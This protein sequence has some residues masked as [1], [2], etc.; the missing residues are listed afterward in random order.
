MIEA[1]DQNQTSAS[2]SL[3]VPVCIPVLEAELETETQTQ[4][5][6]TEAETQTAAT[7]PPQPTHNLNPKHYEQCTVTRG[8]PPEWIAVNV[9]SMNKKEAT[10]RLG[11]PAKSDGMF[12]EGYN[13][14]GQYKPDKPWKAEND[15]DK[16]AAKYRTAINEEYDAMLPKHPTN[17]QYWTDYIALQELAWKI[18]GHPYLLITEGLFK[19]IMACFCALPC[20]ALAGVEQGLTPSDKDPQGKR[21][22]VETLELLARQGFGFIIIFDADSATNINVG[23]A[24]YKL[25]KQLEK[26]KV[27]VYIS[28]GWDIS[29]GKGMDDYIQKNGIDQFKRE[30][31]GKIV[32]LS[33]WEKQ[34]V[35]KLNAQKQLPPS[36]SAL[37]LA[38]KY[39]HLWKHDLEQQTW[40]RYNDKVWE[41][42]ADKVFE[43]EVYTD[44]KLMPQV[45]FKHH[46]Y[47]KNVLE[48]LHLELM[49]RKWISFERSQWIAFND[50]VLE[51]AT[52]KKHNHAPGFMFTSNL[53]HNCPTLDWEKGGDILALCRLHAPSFFAYAM[54][55]QNGDALKVLKLLAFLNGTL[56]YRF[57]QLQMFMLI[58]GAPGAGKG[59]FVRILETAVGVSNFT[60]AKLH[61]LGEHNVIASL[62]DKQLV[63]CPD[64]KKQNSDISGIL[65][66]TGGDTIPYRQIYKPMSSAKFHGSVV[67]VANKN[68][69]VGDT[70]G[71]DRRLSLLQFD[72][73]FVTQDPELEEAMQAEVGVLISLALAMEETQ[74]NNLIRGR[75]E[76]FIPDF[77]RQTW[78]HKTENDS[79]AYFV[80]ERLAPAT[81]KEYVFLGVKNGSPDTT[82][83]GAYLKLCEDNNNGKTY[84]AN[85]FSGHLLEI[86]SE[87]GWQVE[88]KRHGGG[89]V[90]KGVRLR[91]ECDDCPRI[92]DFLASGQTIQA[93]QCRECSTSVPSSVDLKA[94]QGKESVGSVPSNPPHQENNFHEQPPADT[95]EDKQFREPPRQETKQENNNN[96]DDETGKIAYTTTPPAS[97]KPSSPT[98]GGTPAYTKEGEPTLKPT[99]P[100]G[101]QPAQNNQNVGDKQKNPSLTQLITQNWDNK[102]VL[103]EIVL[104]IADTIDLDAL[105]ANFD[106]NQ[107]K[108]IKSAAKSAWRPN[109]ASSA[110][111]RGEKCELMKYGNDKKWKV[112][113]VSGTE[114]I[115]VSGNEV[116]PWLGI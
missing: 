76:G 60:S 37:E 9:R 51:V 87:L 45:E 113:L 1:N 2:D 103:G 80:E 20:I 31:M 52:G 18:D 15:T 106:A 19:A 102:A 21:Y 16:K 28:S 40:R 39:K 66:L 61:H 24:Q 62:I 104:K 110:E 26:F 29:L 95:S 48:F 5:V 94:A 47:I 85:N 67:V 89:W 105:V 81:S 114:V 75:E 11:Y 112:L 84:T 83:F 91:S 108:H 53:T 46:S 82:L 34:F 109:P 50:C 71:I 49:E 98:L 96:I 63:I 111:Y 10:E 73:P 22:L 116:Y 56:T 65:S 23:L 93:Y 58:L 35:E 59:T 69:F 100:V 78:L 14:F 17:K 6:E 54:Y 7:Q 70:I 74:V 41:A 107:I 25:A 36:K 4:T 44:L 72:K 57:A 27:P 68:P 32:D 101:E 13:G 88:H 99:E 38:K 115:N 42:V 8:L 3:S 90:I 64:E 97:S 12:L 86:C 30:V 55:A 77:K 43:R 33:S 79:L 92:S